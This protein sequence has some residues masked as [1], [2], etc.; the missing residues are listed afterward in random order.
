VESEQG[1]LPGCGAVAPSNTEEQSGVN[2]AEETRGAKPRYEAI[3]REQLCWRMVDVERL[4]GEDHAARAI[5]EFV[6]QLDLSG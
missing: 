4:I 6:G 1:I 3:N 5:W 2:K